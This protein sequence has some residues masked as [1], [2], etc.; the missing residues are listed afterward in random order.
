MHLN[1]KNQI[2]AINNGSTRSVLFKNLRARDAVNIMHA[3]LLLLLL[4]NSYKL[5][6]P[7]FTDECTVCEAYSLVDWCVSTRQSSLS[8]YVLFCFNP[9]RHGGGGGGAQRSG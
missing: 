2:N 5:K 8:N 7:I 3:E 1:K 9:V 4:D 6:D